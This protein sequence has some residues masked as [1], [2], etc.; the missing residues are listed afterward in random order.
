[1][2]QF[3]GMRLEMYPMTM[4][5]DVEVITLQITVMRFFP[6]LGCLMAYVVERGSRR[7]RFA[8]LLRSFF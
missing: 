8:L 6:I 3:R 2:K 5:Y 7:P 1:M 4:V